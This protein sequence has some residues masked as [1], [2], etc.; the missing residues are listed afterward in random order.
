VD[1]GLIVV[2]LEGIQFAL[3]VKPVPEKHMVEI[4]AAHRANWPF[5]KRVR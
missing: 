5:D 4:R 2:S 3:Q 1:A